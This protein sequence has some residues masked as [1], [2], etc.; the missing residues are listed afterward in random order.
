MKASKSG[1][2]GGGGLFRYGDKK[3]VDGGAGSGGAKKLQTTPKATTTSRHMQKVSEENLTTIASPSSPSE[4]SLA[5][6]LT[7]PASG[8]SDSEI[9]VAKTASPRSQEMKRSVK[10]EDEE[11]ESSSPQALDYDEAEK[12]ISPTPEK[13]NRA[14]EDAMDDDDEELLEYSPSPLKKGESDD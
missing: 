7:P 3:T 13:S 2:G 10:F 12:M 8:K 4:I 14:D 1:K 5:G 11:A 9:S 6:T